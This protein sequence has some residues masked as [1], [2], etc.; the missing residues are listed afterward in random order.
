MIGFLQLDWMEIGFCG[1]FL[2]SSFVFG[3]ISIR[4]LEWF[5]GYLFEE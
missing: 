2:L 3:Y 5:L 1:I 4:A